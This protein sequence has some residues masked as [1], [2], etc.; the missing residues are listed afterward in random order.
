M[1]KVQWLVVTILFMIMYKLQVNRKESM[2]KKFGTSDTGR[3]IWGHHHSGWTVPWLLSQ[4]QSLWASLVWL[5]FLWRL[6]WLCLKYWLPGASQTDLDLLSTAQGFF[7]TFASLVPVVGS[8]TRQGIVSATLEGQVWEILFLVSGEF[9][10][11]VLAVSYW[12][13]R[14]VAESL[15]S[16]V[17]DRF[18]LSRP[19]PHEFVPVLLSDSPRS[20]FSGSSPSNFS[21]PGSVSASHSSPG[22]TQDGLFW[23]FSIVVRRLW[24]EGL[25][26]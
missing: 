11:S 1:S 23:S 9:I 24:K 19:F 10:S 12:E 18:F 22:C 21:L 20:D 17:L 7:A 16:T 15:P 3:I 6:S 2:R 13:G 4:S 25:S 5:E 26:S 14:E 8:L